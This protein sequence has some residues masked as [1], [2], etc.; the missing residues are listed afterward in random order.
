[1]PQPDRPFWNLPIDETV[2]RTGSS[3]KGLP[4]TEALAR[5][6]RFAASRLVPKKRTGTFTL[7]LGQFSSSIVLMLVG[8]SVISMGVTPLRCTAR[9]ITPNLS[10]KLQRGYRESG[11]GSNEP[12]MGTPIDC[13]THI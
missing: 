4:T 11:S 10:R 7:M 8:V 9:R 5:L 12:V 1:M 3:S 2:S 13:R 6:K